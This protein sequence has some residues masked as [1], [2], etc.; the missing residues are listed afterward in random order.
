M[1]AKLAEIPEDPNP[2]SDNV[3]ATTWKWQEPGE[4]TL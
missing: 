2:D 3:E 1:P 4:H